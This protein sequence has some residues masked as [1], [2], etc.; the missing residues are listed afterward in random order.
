MHS[1]WMVF[2]WWMYHNRRGKCL[3]KTQSLFSL[4][5][6]KHKIVHSFRLQI[7]K[8]M[9]IEIGSLLPF[10][11]WYSISS[12]SFLYT[13]KFVCICPCVSGHPQVHSGT[14]WPGFWLS[15]LLMIFCT[16]SAV[17]STHTWRL[18]V[19]SLM[20]TEK[21]DRHIRPRP[22]IRSSGVQFI[23]DITDLITLNGHY[24]TQIRHTFT[25]HW[26][27]SVSYHVW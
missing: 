13:S 2:S 6:M 3:A 22:E 27:S 18:G 26:K 23:H 20:G 25:D 9:N 21:S 11:I 24:T 16:Q 14:C 4:R 12:F 8:Y 1:M 15:R 5:K 19:S 7:S 17:G 10:S